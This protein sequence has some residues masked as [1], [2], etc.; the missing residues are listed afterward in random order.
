MEGLTR[1]VVKGI[2]W[3]LVGT[4]DTFLI[5]LLIT[6]KLHLAGGI[7]A[8]EVLS[9]ILLYTVHERVWN[10]IQWNRN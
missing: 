9:K 4:L 6:G 7:A 1:S 10:R 2:T 5:S 3:R 8:V